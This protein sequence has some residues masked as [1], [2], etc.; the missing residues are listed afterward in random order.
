M[1]PDPKFL[2]CQC[3]LLKISVI[4]DHELFLIIIKF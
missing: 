2:S 3:L 4:P 1:K